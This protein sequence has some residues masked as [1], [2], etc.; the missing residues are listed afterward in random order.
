MPDQPTNNRTIARNTLMLY[1]RALL[2]MLIGLYTSRVILHVLGVTDFGIYNAVGGIIGLFGVVTG[3]LS[4][5]TSRFITVAI[6]KGNQEITNKTFGNIKVIYY[7]LCFLVVL[8]GETI[9]L[10]FLYHKMTIPADRMTAAFWVYQFT[11]VSAVLSF[12]CVPYNSAIIAHERM[13]AF[14]YIS[15]LDAIFK[16][17]IC[18]L[19]VIIPL[20][21]LIVYSTLIFCVGIIDRIIYAIYCEKRFDEVKAKP[22]VFKEQFREIVVLSG[23]ALSG[24]IAYVSYTQGLN[25]L[26]NLFFGPVVNAAR[27][28]ALQ[29][30]GV[31]TQFVGNFQTAINPQ[32]TKSYAA[33]H[34]ER[35]HQLFNF[36]SKYSFYLLFFLS[37]PVVIEAPYILHLW[38]VKVPEHTVSFLRIIF[39]YE[40]VQT[41]AGAYNTSVLATGNMKWFQIV[42]GIIRLSI[43]PCCYVLLKFFHKQP[44]SVFIVLAISEVLSVIAKTFIVLP[45]IHYKKLDYLK[46]VI[47]PISAIFVLSPIAPIL[48]S[49]LM[50][51]SFIRLACVVLTSCGGTLIFIWIIG[52]NGHERSVIKDMIVHRLLVKIGLVHEK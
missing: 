25:I 41:L 9:G 44:E 22:R 3:S 13:S 27:G 4:N 40:W 11:I 8:L 34:F 51:S 2:M 1:G 24:N 45:M 48:I 38:L 47:L 17:L 23:W 21:K 43:F 35:M 33:G 15:L 16:L 39:I 42:D 20:D 5:A 31:I 46:E 50:K 28:V 10:W 12:I 18:Y 32:I 7:A 30:Q 29:V 49:E 36:S 19:L 26:L 6:G 14:A 37:L 52:L